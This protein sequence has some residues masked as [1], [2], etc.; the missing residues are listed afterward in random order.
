MKKIKI[1]ALSFQGGVS[2][3]ISATI[4]AVRAIGRG[5]CEVVAVKRKKELVELDALIIPGGE[6]TVLSRLITRENCWDEIRSIPNI[7][8]TC[9]GAILLAKKVFGQEDGGQDSLGIMNIEVDRNAYGSQTESFEEKIHVRLG[10][11]KTTPRILDA[12][13][14][15]APKIKKAGVTCE[16]LAK[17][18]NGEIVAVSERVGRN[19]YLA[20]TFHPE[21]STTAFHEYFIKSVCVL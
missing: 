7:F 21:L 19:F 15:R 13:F 18:A 5:E 10:A 20:T 12:I 11:D 4:N 3:H 6:S 1:G 14:I 16:V 8:G 9:A 2:E 17:R